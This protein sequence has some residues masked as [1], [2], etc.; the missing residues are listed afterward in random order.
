MGSQQLLLLTVGVII[1]FSALMFGI[2]MFVAQ[3]VERNRDAV[4]NDLHIIANSAQ[5][6][7]HKLDEQGGGGR[8]FTGFKIPT[9]LTA[10]QNGTYTI[11][12]TTPNTIVFQGV[13]VEDSD[14]VMGCSSSS[15]KVTYR[16]SVTA[17]ES[18]LHQ[19]Y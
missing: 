16:I 12:N 17:D 1:V 19:V 2:D 15:E 8:V 6:Y 9:Q 18:T 3:A 10:N 4:V 14:S 13:G 11:I 7:Y 5:Q